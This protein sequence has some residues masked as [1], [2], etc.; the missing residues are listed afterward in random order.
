MIHKKPCV[1]CALG[2]KRRHQRKVYAELG[3]MIDRVD[4]K[5]YMMQEL[6]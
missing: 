2:V 4:R 6:L 5:V 3:L 1:L